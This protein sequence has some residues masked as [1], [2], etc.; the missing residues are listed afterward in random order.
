M[1]YS[2]KDLFD[3]L[4]W[5][6]NI[7]GIIGS[8]EYCFGNFVGGTA[9]LYETKEEQNRLTIYYLK[10]PEHKTLTRKFNSEL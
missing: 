5:F 10:C 7:G 1:K 9:Y 8:T 2:Y 6:K 3:D 4:W